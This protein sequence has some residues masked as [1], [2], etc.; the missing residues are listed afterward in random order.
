M[1]KWFSAALF[2]IFVLPPCSSGAGYVPGE[3][4]V[5]MN[6]GA[7]FEAVGALN[8]RFGAGRI[9]RLHHLNAAVIR[10]GG[11]EDLQGVIDAYA[12]HPD[13]GYAEPN[14]TAQAQ[15]VFPNDPY[16]DL[17]WHLERIG[18]PYVWNDYRGSPDVVVSVVDSGVESSHPDLAG[19]LAGGYN[20][21]H[22]NPFPEDDNGHGT[23]IAGIIGAETNNGLGIAGVSWGVT[24]MP[25]KSLDNLG[26]GAYSD[27]AAGIVFSADNGAHV[28]NLSLGGENR[29][30]LL[31]E[32]VNY[33]NRMGCVVVA[34][35]GNADEGAVF[36]PAAYRN[37]IAVGASNE[38]DLRCG[39]E[40]WG[41]GSGSNYGPEIDLAAPGNNILST[42]PG[43]G[44][45]SGSGT[46]A[47]A[48]VVSGAA[49]VLL[50]ANPALIPGEIR[51]LMNS[52][53]EVQE[54]GWNEYTG[55]GRF[56]AAR[57]VDNIDLPP[58]PGLPG[59]WPFL[60]QPGE[61]FRWLNPPVGQ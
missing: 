17:Q 15:A 56:D 3:I 58:R 2:L 61:F 53:A 55:H 10:F 4:V 28:I 47:A 42:F 52:T 7:E 26:S 57:A 12:G 29:S 50:S 54:G 37:V 18:M 9:L 30:F 51:W 59:R 60:K 46:S 49:A 8:R 1:R 6:P 39:S 14:F 5:G 21:V 35:T 11:D 19:M 13:V 38:N 24:L 16:F 44:F 45:A 43:G 41:P 23:Y 40:D 22:D 34:A 20:F 31:E 27:V 48:A 33:A 32:A 25:V 36:Y